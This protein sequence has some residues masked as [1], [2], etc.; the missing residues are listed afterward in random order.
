MRL[1]LT[2]L[3]HTAAGY[4]VHT[5]TARGAVPASRLRARCVAAERPFQ[6]QS[7]SALSAKAIDQLITADPEKKKSWKGFKR[8]KKASKRKTEQK[9]A[10]SGR[11]FGA[12]TLVTRFDRRPAAGADCA[13]GADQPYESCCAPCH[14]EG[15]AEDPVALVRARYTAYAYRLPDFLISTTSASHEEWQADRTEWKRQLLNFCDSFAFEGLELG[16]HTTEAD[17]SEKVS[18]R[19]TIV[20]K[21][22]IKMLDLL[23]TSTFVREDDRWMY[24][25]GEVSYEASALAEA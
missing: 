8:G 21:G 12:T 25:H 16:E 22:A 7:Q 18:F 14:A 9:A 17:G 24:S 3:L 2:L 13:C 6:T 20:E 19:A 10:G 11:G 15:S 23:E 1:P 4:Y 5:L